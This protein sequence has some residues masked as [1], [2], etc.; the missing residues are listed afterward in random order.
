[1]L[2][3]AAFDRWIAAGISL[4]AVLSVATRTMMEGSSM[5]IE[6][7][8]SATVSPIENPDQMV[9][10]LAELPIDVRELIEQSASPGTFFAPFYRVLARAVERSRVMVKDGTVGSRTRKRVGWYCPT[11]DFVSAT[12]GT[13]GRYSNECPP[14]QPVYVIEP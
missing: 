9:R 10:W 7:A 5:D 13:K 2:D 4:G 6:Q 12:H 3:E 1:V 11:H 14:A 8:T